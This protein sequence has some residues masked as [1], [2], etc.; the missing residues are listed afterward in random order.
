MAGTER[1]FETQR[2][3]LDN[4]LHTQNSDRG[5]EVDHSVGR[6]QLMRA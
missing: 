3:Q 5:R 1:L 6:N 4:S 2:R